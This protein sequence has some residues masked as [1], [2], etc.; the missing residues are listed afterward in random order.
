MPYIAT[1]EIMSSGRKAKKKKEAIGK[2]SRVQ[3]QLYEVT[4]SR[5][6]KFATATLLKKAELNPNVL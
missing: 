2:N 4:Q 1:S 6:R 5:K 3:K